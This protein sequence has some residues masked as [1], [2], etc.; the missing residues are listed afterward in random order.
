[1]R[2]W[3]LV[4]WP[5]IIPD[6]I[7]KQARIHTFL[8]IFSMPTPMYIYIC[9]LVSWSVYSIF[10]TLHHVF[11]PKIQHYTVHTWATAH[12][13]KRDWNHTSQ[14]GLANDNKN[15]GCKPHSQRMKGEMPSPRKSHSS[16]TAATAQWAPTAQGR[17]A[18]KHPSSATA[19]CDL[20]FSNSHFLHRIHSSLCFS[21]PG[22]QGHSDFMP[23]V[24]QKS[25][26]SHSKDNFQFYIFSQAFQ[27]WLNREWFLKI[28]T[29]SKNPGDNNRGTVTQLFNP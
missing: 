29:T 25:L 10:C 11:Q 21:G 28:K 12:G 18:P 6:Y 22:A 16:S 2:L 13:K 26:S 20:Q 9:I 5:E 14:L 8:R 19:I 24:K 4:T 1:M 3:I 15:N 7:S 27:L 17:A 23:S